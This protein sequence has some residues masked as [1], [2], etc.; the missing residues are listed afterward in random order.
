MFTIA[1]ENLNL[2][3][4]IADSNI[5]L[6]APVKA[7]E[8]LSRLFNSVAFPLPVDSLP[9]TS[10]A[11]LRRNLGWALSF[12]KRHWRIVLEWNECIEPPKEGLSAVVRLGLECLSSI[13][14]CYTF[15]SKICQGTSLDQQAVCAWLQ[16]GSDMLASTKLSSIPDIQ[17]VLCQQLHES[18]QIAHSFPDVSMFIEEAFL[19]LIIDISKDDT[20]LQS[21]NSSLQVSAHSTI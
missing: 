15:S 12:Y 16:C 18:V 17:H 10:T 19:P 9:K 3:S 21:L 8:A 7:A 13:R 6:G 2:P 14:T 4:S 20:R 5:R 1:L 11:D